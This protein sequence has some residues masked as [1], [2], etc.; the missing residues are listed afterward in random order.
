[1]T[2]ARVAG[3]GRDPRR[4]DLY[5]AEAEAFAGTFLADVVGVATL[6]RHA[7]AITSAPW[8]RTHVGV[9]GP[10]VVAARAD[11]LT[12]RFI[13]SRAEIRIAPIDATLVTLLHELAHAADRAGSPDASGGHGPSFRRWELD[14]VGAVCGPAW[15][16]R[17]GA[18]LRGCGLAPNPPSA[19]S[20]AVSTW[21]SV[22]DLAALAPAVD[23]GR[24]PLPTPSAPSPGPLALGPAPG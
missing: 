9:P 2:S 5:D 17:L 18:V 6:V 24:L 23:V 22:L 3:R 19:A 8:W 4:T 11:S 13:P 1:M 15:A 14:L 16:T 7:G 10:R 21:A 12:S 20:A